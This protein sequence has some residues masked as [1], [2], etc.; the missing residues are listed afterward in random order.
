V[1]YAPLLEERRSAG[2]GAGHQG[3]EVQAVPELRRL[4]GVLHLPE[5]LLVPGLLHELLQLL[6]LLRLVRDV[7][8]L[9]NM[10]DV[11]HVRVPHR[12]NWVGGWAEW[13]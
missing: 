11:H 8:G 2:G 9:P 6:H 7:P 3:L 12:D 1:R 10:P 4:P 5:L 13:R